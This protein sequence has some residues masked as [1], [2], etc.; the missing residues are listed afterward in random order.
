MWFGV[1]T[2]VCDRWPMKQ[3]G[4]ES[5]SADV[6]YSSDKLGVVWCL[7]LPLRASTLL[8]AAQV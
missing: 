2:M 6:L 4:R 7:S 3:K 5:A 8:L 1:Q